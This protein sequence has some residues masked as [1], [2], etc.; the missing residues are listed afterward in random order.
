MKNF[1]FA[2]VAFFFSI[3]LFSQSTY[4]L[5]GSLHGMLPKKVYLLNYFGVKKNILDSVSVD[6][7]GQFRFEF[8]QNASVGMYSVNVGY[9]QYYDIIF[10]RENISFSLDLN[11]GMESIHFTESNENRIF[12]QYLNRNNQFTWQIETIRNQ[13]G[14][15]NFKSIE[16][17]QIELK[18]YTDL[19]LLADSNSQLLAS[20]II[21]G[22]IVPRSPNYQRNYFHSFTDSL[23]A[24]Y[25]E[26]H[27]FDFIGFNDERLIQSPLYEV[28]LR[29]YFSKLLRSR[30]V[31]DSVYYSHI[32]SIMQK[33]KMNGLVNDFVISV[34][35]AQL[36]YDEKFDILDRFL[37]AFPVSQNCENDT[38]L[39]KGK[40]NVRY[41]KNL[42]IGSVAP[43][44]K[45]ENT[46]KGDLWLHQ[47]K[48]NYTLI[49][50]WRSTCEHCMAS[51]PELKKLSQHYSK[52]GLQLVTVSFDTNYSIWKSALNQGASIWINSCDLKGSASQLIQLY[53]VLYTPKF[54]LLNKDKI[55][56]E[57][58]FSLPD[59]T[60]GLGNILDK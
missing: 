2:I 45:I 39:N 40:S 27:F 47:I 52:N 12:Y 25:L 30:K 18:R 23:E 21:K 28:K 19:I 24:V 51:L 36:D 43:D 16:T 17:F 4:Y 32:E 1:Y 8:P 11:S 42:K 26:N 48:S 55:I 58:Y 14:I 57:K 60:V 53:H 31:N 3:S 22:I 29:S 59:L 15:P 46:E 49:V 44:F 33:A 41:L 9:S 5:K 37:N 13:K 50:L 56:I 38:I 54:Y 35:I 20:T 7:N 10:N 6:K 34:I